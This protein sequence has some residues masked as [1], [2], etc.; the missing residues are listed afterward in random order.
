MAL[1]VRRAKK[2]TAPAAS[3]MVVAPSGLTHPLESE[4][5]RERLHF[6]QQWYRQARVAQADNRTQMAIDED[7]YD[8]IQMEAEDLRTLMDRNQ[9]IL[10]F[11][12][13]KNT[14]NWILGVERKNRIDYRVLP[15]KKKGAQGA[16]SKTQVMKY[17]QDSSK[18]EYHRSW[19]F[20][21]AV[22]AGLGWT[23]Y[24]A[25]SGVDGCPIFER[26]EKWRNMWFDHL[27]ASNDGSDW[28][29]VIRSKWA[30]L[31][32]ISSMF[33]ERAEALRVLAEGV[34]S[35]YPYLPDEMVTTDLA[36]EFDLESDID[37]MFGGPFDTNRRRIKPVEM[38]YRMPANV[39]ILRM[40]DTDTPYGALHGS[41]FRP[42]H[43]DHQY[44]VRGGH[45]DLVPQ[46]VMTVRCAI[47]AG[48]TYLQDV[49][50]PYNHR[51]FP[52]VPMFCYR[53]QRNGMPYGVIRDIRDPQSDLNKRKSRALF[54]MTSEKVWYETGSITDPVKFY[55]E[56]NR[57][58]GMA[59]V[60]KGALT[61]NQI[62]R[63]KDNV[64]VKEHVE[65]ARDD[66]RFIEGIS[67]VTPENKGTIRKDLSGKAI[68]AIQLQGHTTSGVFFDNYYYAFQNGG[69]LK[70]SLIEQYIDSEQ[71]FRITGDR[72]KDDFL[73]VN[74]RQPDGS[75]K[76]AMQDVK[77]DFIV[78][79]QDFR[80]T[81]RLTMLQMLTDLILGLAQSGQANV[82]L[83]ILDLAVD[84]MDDLPN[85]DEIIARIRKISG[86]RS[87]D[88]E[89]TDEEKAKVE[90]QDA[91]AGQEAQMLKALQTALLQGQA[92]L[93][94]AQA[95]NANA[96][97]LKNK[98][99]A[100][101]KRLDGFLK[102]MEAA[103]SVAAAPALTAAADALIAE[104]QNLEGGN[105]PSPRQLSETPTPEGGLS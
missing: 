55:D 4:M 6:L 88:E 89:M 59:E 65:L 46:R 23:E 81:L 27:G 105:G 49:L 30:D 51:Q 42:E 94:N 44:L 95:A 92:A 54:L 29:Y 58:D 77:A 75:I 68:E 9:P 24:G 12:V 1:P 48:A 7:Y 90:E 47:W 84:M 69:E 16:T 17:V 76:N 103:G 39:N 93:A 15:R 22:K 40:R 43:E 13:V 50:S 99:D 82:G 21:S 56:N 2:K 33:P 97:A 85:K 62:E 71:E 36:S 86:Q 78:T 32:V 64:L 37:S 80:E 104:S 34:N 60:N 102:A 52:F 70:V 73:V 18:G 98:V 26:S 87:P 74:E 11:N 38:W 66:E 57:P 41:I 100:Q 28:R 91:V 45:F 101:M 83:A 31:D 53:F 10:T 5:W 79:K 61:T 35:L 3:A 67:G 63:I 20:E 96:Q 72:K 25:Q 14:V 19:A 8:G